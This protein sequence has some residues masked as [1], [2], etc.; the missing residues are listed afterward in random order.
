MT[1][2]DIIITKQ[3]FALVFQVAVKKINLPALV[4]EAFVREFRNEIDIMR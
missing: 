4:D 1:N 3:A 2:D